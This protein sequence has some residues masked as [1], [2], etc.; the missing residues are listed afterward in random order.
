MAWFSS[1]S[2]K[3]TH[4]EKKRLKEIDE[5]IQNISLNPEFD[6]ILKQIFNKK[7][8]KKDGSGRKK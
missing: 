7:G 4:D 8:A 3:R 1:F 2:K 6:S 5:E